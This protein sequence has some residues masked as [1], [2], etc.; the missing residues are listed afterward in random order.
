MCSYPAQIVWH[1]LKGG[2][3]HEKTDTDA[4]AVLVLA[5]VEV[6]V[7]YFLLKF[8]VDALMK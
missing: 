2:E 8:I 5:A 3:C 1:Y 6:A 7:R 4:V